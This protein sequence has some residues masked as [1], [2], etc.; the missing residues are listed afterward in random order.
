[1]M[2]RAWKTVSLPILE[3]EAH[4]ESTK[5]RLERKVIA[6]TVKLISLPRSNPARRALPHALNIY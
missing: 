3:A 1:M 2:L 6:R 4:L 5:K